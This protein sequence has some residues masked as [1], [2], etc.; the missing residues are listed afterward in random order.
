MNADQAERDRPERATTKPAEKIVDLI[1]GDQLYVRDRKHSFE[2]AVVVF[3][4]VRSEGREGVNYSD[5]IKA[6]RPNRERPGNA[7]SIYRHNRDYP[8]DRLQINSRSA[9]ALIKRLVARAPEQSA[10]SATELASSSQ[11]AGSLNATNEY[12]RQKGWD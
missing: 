2:P 12:A 5:C 11:G 3:Y 6:W 4:R 7:G 8:D 10:P 9:F 1:N